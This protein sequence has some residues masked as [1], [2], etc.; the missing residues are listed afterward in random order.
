MPD[1]SKF[2]ENFHDPKSVKMYWKFSWSQI[3]QN[4]LKIFVIPNLSKFIENFC[5]ARPVKIYWKFLWSQTW[6]N[7]MKIFVIP[8]L[9]K[10]IEN[11]CNARPVK[12]YWKCLWCRTCQN[13]VTFEAILPLRISTDLPWDVY[14]Y[15]SLSCYIYCIFTSQF[16]TIIGKCTTFRHC[17]HVLVFTV[18]L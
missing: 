7:L 6:Q 16:L 18:S 17:R 2:I 13:L 8:N 3:C 5:D 14:R 11:F 9:S 1:L 10:F 15:E 12:I 4:L